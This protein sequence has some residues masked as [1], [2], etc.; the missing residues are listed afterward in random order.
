MDADRE[1]RRMGQIWSLDLL[2]YT[3]KYIRYYMKNSA[4]TSIAMDA[5]ASSDW[6]QSD[7]VIG[8]MTLIG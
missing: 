7:E 1:Y 3:R 2:V 6:N 5:V 8:R 4:E